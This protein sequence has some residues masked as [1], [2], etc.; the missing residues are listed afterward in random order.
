[1]KQHWTGNFKRKPKEDRTSADGIVH[2]SV[3][4][5][6]RWNELR[7][8]QQG[9]HIRNL[10]REVTFPFVI[11]GQPGEDDRPV[12]TAGGKQI[13]KYIADFVYERKTMT[14]DGAQWSE[15]IEEHKGF[16]AEDA[17]LKLRFFEAL[18]DKRVFIHTERGKSKYRRDTMDT[19]L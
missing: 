10:K 15:V 4:Q 17:I 13:M 8:L 5:M 19:L 11:K 1:M 14:P 3:S 6:A 2:S 16:M 9:G 18:Y 12:R 7:L